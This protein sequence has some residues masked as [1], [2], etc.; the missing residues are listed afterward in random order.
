VYPLA[1]SA[2]PSLA[3][4][5]SGYVPLLR[6]AQFPCISGAIPSGFQP[7][8]ITLCV[9]LFWFPLLPSLL[10]QRRASLR[11]HG[12]SL[13]ANF[14]PENPPGSVP[15]KRNWSRLLALDGQFHRQFLNPAVRLFCLLN[16]ASRPRR[17]GRSQADITDTRYRSYHSVRGLCL[18][19]GMSG[20]SNL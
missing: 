20:F 8:P 18:A 11:L 12:E 7:R 3:D 6:A 10:A 9:G 17:Q 5:S 19:S 1:V 16:A 14:Y 2:E 4:I 15:P 13:P